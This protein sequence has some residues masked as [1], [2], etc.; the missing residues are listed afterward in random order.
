MFT[1]HTGKVLKTGVGS[2]SAKSDVPKIADCDV[3]REG[4]P[5]SGGVGRHIIAPQILPTGGESAGIDVGVGN[6]D[7][8]LRETASEQHRTE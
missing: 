7:L 6:V 2:I 5:G 3:R 4:G 1:Q 8:P